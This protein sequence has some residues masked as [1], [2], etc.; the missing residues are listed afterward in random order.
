MVALRGVLGPE[1]LQQ[2]VHGVRPTLA[3]KHPSPYDLFHTF[4]D[5]SGQDLSWF[6]RSWFFE[7]WKLDQAIDTRQRQQATRWR[8]VIEN[9]GKAP[10]PVHAGDHPGR[11][12]G[13]QPH[14]AGRGLARGRERRTVRVAREPAVQSIEIDRGE[15]F[16]GVGS[17][18]SGLAEVES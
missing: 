5:V 9:R 10:M 15:G 11:R 7:T 17:K 18:Q 6:W 8:S 2:G 14:D 12:T 16:P 1:T 3:Y 13:G 4:E